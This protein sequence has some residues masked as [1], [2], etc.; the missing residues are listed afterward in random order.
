MYIRI[1]Q[2]IGNYITYKIYLHKAKQLIK[3]CY[4]YTIDGKELNEEEFI[5]YMKKHHNKE[6]RFK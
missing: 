1:L 2:K 3:N 5:K 6:V 4:T